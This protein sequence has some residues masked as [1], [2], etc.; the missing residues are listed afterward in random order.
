MNAPVTYRLLAGLV[1][2]HVLAFIYAL[3][4]GGIYMK[5]SFEY[6]HQA[7]NLINYGSWY[8]A[9][10]YGP[11]NPDYFSF[12]PP[13]YALF[14]AGIRLFS[15]SD[16]A[17][18]FVQNLLSIFN[19]LVVFR[20]LSKYGKPGKNGDLLFLF[21]VLMFPTQWVM[22]N[23]V[24]SEILFQ[25]LMLGAFIAMLR[26]LEK[27]GFANSM[28]VFAWS[29]MLLFTKPVALLLPVVVAILLL[30]KVIQ[31]RYTWRRILLVL[32]PALLPLLSIHVI[33]LQHQHQTGYY[34]YTSMMA[35]NQYKFNARFILA[36]R[37]GEVYA[38]NWADSC[39]KVFSNAPDYGKRYQWMKDAGDQVI[40]KYPLDYL[41]LVIRGA[42]TFFTDPGRHD[43]AVFFQWT[44]SQH[45]GLF[46]EINAK[47][48]SGFT[49]WLKQANT[50][51]LIWLLLIALF[52]ISVLLVIFSGIRQLTTIRFVS[53]IWI[54]YVVA[55]TGIL[56]VARYRT[57]IYPEWVLLFLMV[58]YEWKS[59]IQLRKKHVRNT[60]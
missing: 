27:P 35:F 54:L 50:F 3:E 43:L 5:D 1:I 38:E 12:R 49:D 34:H 14:I 45:N 30:W 16:H 4:S 6:L 21:A 8:A 2:L 42:G 23:M 37:F 28:V 17:I 58:F 41:F 19:L 15:T 13:F 60:I 29:S 20:L 39:K 51:H 53:W 18:L 25:T 10:F 36:N 48:F 47:G 22:A 55:A 11:L 33:C 32:L 44:D 7:G 57:A 56:G 52:N 9:D 46:Y 40:R 59:R 26:L 31:L 24:M